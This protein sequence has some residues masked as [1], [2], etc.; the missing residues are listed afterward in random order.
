MRAKVKRLLASSALAQ[1]GLAFFIATGVVSLSNFVF[2]MVISRMLGPSNYGALGALLNVMLVLSVPLGA[3]QAAV[4]QAESSRR[5]GGRG[6]IDIAGTTLRA[7]VVGAVAMVMLIAA[8]PLVVEFLH[9]GSL[10]SVVVLASWLVPA[11]VGVVLQGALMGRLHFAPVALASLVGAGAGRLLFGVVLVGLGGG[12]IGAMAASVIGQ[13]I[14]TGVIAIVLLPEFRRG[15]ERTTGGIGIRE[16]VLSV[17]ALAGFWILGSEDTVLARHFLPARE[18]GLYAAAATAGR[19]ALFLPGAIALIAFPRFSRDKGHG[20]AAREALRWS[21]AG[22]AFLGLM[23]AVVLAAVPSLVINVLFGSEYLGGVDAVRI[24]GV[25][26][27]GLGLIGLLIYFHLARESLHSL[28]GWV[29][30]AIAFIGIEEFHSSLVSIAL[31]MVVSVSVVGGAMLLSAVHGLLREPLVPVPSVQVEDDVQ[32][33]AYDCDLS[34]VVPYYNPGSALAKHVSALAEVLTASQLCFEIIAVSDGSTDGSRQS[35]KGMLPGILRSVEFSHN[36]GKG[37]ALRA[38]LSQ[39]RGRYL[40][41]IDSDGDIPAGQL[42]AFLKVV[43]DE[44]PDIVTGSKRHPD[45]VVYYPPLRRAYSWGYQQLIRILFHLQIKDTQTGVKLI[46]KD[47][48]VEVLPLMVEK[49]FAFDL[50]LFVVARHL[51][52]NK[53]IELPVRIERRFTSTVSIKAVKGMLLDTLGIY[54]RLHFL[55][56]YD[57]DREHQ[58]RVVNLQVEG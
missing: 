1:G 15:R 58:G 43:M 56:Y 18:A 16:S 13:V 3:L 21:F 42:S 45:S 47:V 35:L 26:A 38:G 57:R 17:L 52:F 27:A 36:Y 37:Q 33:D 48:L 51:G 32:E 46:R 49:H 14:T 39:G 9:L 25:E 53:I 23:A 50:E 6:G 12:V 4:T 22:T 2:H 41:F 31:V 34:L 20:E 30:A 54:Y 29:G 55:H 24:L 19:I 11:V 7:A 5:H 40:G 10:W 8:S 28:Y 44:E